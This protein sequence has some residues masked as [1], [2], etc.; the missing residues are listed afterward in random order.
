MTNMKFIIRE[1]LPED[2]P[3]AFELVKG[4]SIDHK[5]EDKFKITL[6]QFIEER[7]LYGCL[8]AIDHNNYVVGVA[9]YYFF[10]S[11][12]VGKSLFLDDLFVDESARGN[13]I[14]NSLLATIVEMGKKENCKK[15]KWQV[16]HW[17]DKAIQLYKSM[18]AIIDGEEW[19]CVMD[20]DA[21]LS[22]NT[23]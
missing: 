2:L 11:T 16:A 18:G 1:A 8:V 22:Y 3:Q 4:L 6:E 23:A 7:D 5:M 21:I 19:N 9:T 20:E 12:W 13:G 14:G 17:N 10:Y 15:I